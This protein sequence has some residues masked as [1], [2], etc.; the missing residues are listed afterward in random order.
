MRKHKKFIRELHSINDSMCIITEQSRGIRSTILI[1]DEFRLVRILTP[2]IEIYKCNWVNSWKAKSYKIC[3][4]ATKPMKA[5]KS[6]RKAQR[7]ILEV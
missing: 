6:S 4:S 2:Y 1:V 7:L 5:S 3:Q